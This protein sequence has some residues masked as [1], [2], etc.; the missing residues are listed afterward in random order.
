MLTQADELLRTV[1]GLRGGSMSDT[2]QLVIEKALDHLRVR[3]QFFDQNA[4]YCFDAGWTEALAENERRLD[5]LRTQI[6]ALTAARAEPNAA[7]SVLLSMAET[8][9]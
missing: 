2:D 6:E 3:Y 7:A 8:E 4:S 5:V 9:T 1:D